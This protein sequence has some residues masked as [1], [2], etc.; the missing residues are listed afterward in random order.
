MI[1]NLMR[2]LW[3]REVPSALKSAHQMYAGGNY[4]AA[5]E[6]YSKL[7]LAAERE[8]SP[9]T[10]WLYL[11]VAR[12]YIS[13]GEVARAMKDLEHGLSLLISAGLDDKAYLIGHQFLAQLINLQREDQAG[14]LSEF[15]RFGLPG[16][17]L[18]TVP[19]TANTIQVLPMRCTSCEGP[20]RLVEVRW[21]DSHTAECPYCG[22]PVRVLE[23]VR[24]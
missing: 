9:H 20:I 8:L 15:L 6:A 23:K 24:E 3:G 12:S 21:K 4:A 16:Y 14:E 13:D 1:R 10:A 18:S 11:Q 19:Q 17:S 2:S 5:A 22:S 7:A